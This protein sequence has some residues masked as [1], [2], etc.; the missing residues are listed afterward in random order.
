MSKKT[1]LDEAV[2]KLQKEGG[3][4]NAKKVL[5]EWARSKTPEQK[6][7]MAQSIGESAGNL[8]IGLRRLKSGQCPVCGVT[9]HHRLSKCSGKLSKFQT[10]Y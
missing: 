3:K 10:R 6:E 2:E 4:E 1:K 7:A 8:L 5:G 9:R